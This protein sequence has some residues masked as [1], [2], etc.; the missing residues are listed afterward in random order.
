M[1]GLPFTLFFFQTFLA[2]FVNALNY[3]K[4]AAD[5]WRGMK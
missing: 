5:K 2:G 4:F 3:V 1:D